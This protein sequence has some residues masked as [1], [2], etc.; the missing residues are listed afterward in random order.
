MVTPSALDFGVV[1]QGQSVPKSL[2]VQNIT[3]G[4]VP[5]GV[6]MIASTNSGDFQA[7][8]CPGGVL[9]AG[10]SCTLTVTF[11]PQTTSP[12]RAQFQLGSQRL[13]DLGGTGTPSNAAAGVSL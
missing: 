9:A 10:A 7:D 6:S 3:G 4:D 5:V 11:K 1:T 13:V 2:T 12:E 8:G